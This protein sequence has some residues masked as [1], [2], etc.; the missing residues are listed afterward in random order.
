MEKVIKQNE[1]HYYQFTCN[2][3]KGPQLLVS[4]GSVR[5]TVKEGFTN[6]AG[7]TILANALVP[8]SV[9]P[10]LISTGVHEG[11]KRYTL[12]ITG[13]KLRST[14][15]VSPFNSEILS[16]YQKE[17]IGAPTDDIDGCQHQTW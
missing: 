1:C 4:E 2:G 9:D 15:E 6:E 12:F 17:L 14:Y 10:V 11:T 16:V 7:P 13:S 5:Y 8:A 3:R